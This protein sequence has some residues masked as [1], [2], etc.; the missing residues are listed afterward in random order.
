M[1]GVG[2][3]V[4]GGEASEGED[5][6]RICKDEEGLIRP[7]ACTGSMAS[8]HPHCLQQWIVQR[9]HSGESVAEAHVCEVCHAAYGVSAR[10]QLR[11]TWASAC[12]AHA[13]SLYTEAAVIV[14]LTLAAT[15]SLFT[16]AK[17]AE[18]HPA[19]RGLVVNWLFV[20]GVV[21]YMSGRW[22]QR[23]YWRWLEENLNVVL[24]ERPL[25]AAQ[26]AVSA[27]RAAHDGSVVLSRGMPPRRW[28][29]AMAV[30]SGQGSS[31]RPGGARNPRAH[32]RPVVQ[33]LR[34]DASSSEED[35]DSVYSASSGDD[36][37]VEAPAG[38][39]PA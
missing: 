30:G 31:R 34:V 7:C 36:S 24:V 9:I 21:Y 23:L 32:P 2:A 13:W 1:G 10:H 18:G 27:S 25:L 5:E 35:A 19:D 14:L 16:H 22:L 17:D 29:Q 28:A 38:Q 11:P 15:A 6:C 3:G 8:V 39:R 33:V 26:L 4:G 37:D 12:G 20:V